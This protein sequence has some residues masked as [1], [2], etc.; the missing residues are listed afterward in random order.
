MKEVFTFVMKMMDALKRNPPN[1][2]MQAELADSQDSC[3]M[4]SSMHNDL[5]SA[6]WLSAIYVPL[7]ISASTQTIIQIVSTC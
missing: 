7:N 3:Y 1:Q 6:G 2:R 5:S 4:S